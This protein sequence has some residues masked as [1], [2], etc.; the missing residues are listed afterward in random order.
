MKSTVQHSSFPPGAD[1]TNILGVNYVH[2]EI[3]GQGDLYVTRHGIP[4]IPN[5][6]PANW[7]EAS[8]F[9]EN[10]ERL[11]G[12]STIYRLP[13]RS[14]N[15]RS[16]DLVVKWCRVG[17]EVPVSTL[18][19]HQFAQV[20]FNS[21]YEEF[22]LVM[23]MRDSGASRTIRTH[24]PLAIYSPLERV[25]LW[26]SGRDESMIARKKAKYRDVELDIYRE[27]ILIYEWVEGVTAVEALAQ[28]NLPT[29][30][31]LK[32]LRG[33]TDQ[34]A[35]D[36][37]A[38]GFEV[39]DMKPHH[40]IVRLQPDGS[41]LSRNGRVAYALVD[42]ELLQRTPQ[43]E[44]EVVASRR[45]AYLVRQRDRFEREAPVEFPAHLKPARVLGV[46]YVQ[47][48][49]E[50]THGA[51]WVVGRDPSLFDYFQP[52]RWR[53][54][55]REKLSTANE[56][57]R[58]RTKDNINL[59]WKVSRVGE[60]PDL[61]PAKARAE[62]AVRHG[63][64]SPFEE[65]SIALDLAH[66]GFATVYPRAIYMTGRE[67]RDAEYALDQ[68]RYESHAILLA[69]DGEPVLRHD[70]NYITVWGFWNGLD[71]MLATRDADYITAI[72]VRHAL[73]RGLITQRAHTE[74]MASVAD[75]LRT[76]GF[77]DLNP[78]GSHYLLSM[79]A[80][81]L[82][83]LDADGLPSVRMCNFGMVRRRA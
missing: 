17:S 35:R 53:R 6:H 47:G 51:L 82:L 43:H 59:V 26:Q 69:P 63:Y 83:L 22:A 9:R 2:V 40:L 56:V 29:A 52:E 37:A 31:R 71:E 18:T 1:R 60:A 64:N 72:N 54:T 44:Q 61:S 41:L 12:T 16:V 20:E 48:H 74:V 14:V 27:Y 30:H 3:P 68:S 80:D 42:F 5:L 24:R 4:F 45:A 78:K 77:E 36:L 39:L 8:W 66:A 67:S 28:T 19:L 33:L 7:F 49:T 23:E 62:E 73:E 75:R 55:R 38:Q 10:R 70:H 25:E 58:T 81:G 21:P 34:A 65:F 46:D 15:G 13:T 32:H 11:E 79:S 76:L 57:Y 50:S